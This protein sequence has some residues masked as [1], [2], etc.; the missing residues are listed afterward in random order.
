MAVLAFEDR[1]FGQHGLDLLPF[2]FDQLL[3]FDSR[4]KAH[5]FKVTIIQVV[6]PTHQQKFIVVFSGWWGSDPAPDLK[7][8]CAIMTSCSSGMSVVLPNKRRT[9]RNSVQILFRKSSIL[10]A[11]VIIAAK[12]AAISGFFEAVANWAESAKTRF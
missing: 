9:R 10:P 3:G 5:G 7:S 1:D 4:S 8:T 12:R 2:P 6:A 11:V